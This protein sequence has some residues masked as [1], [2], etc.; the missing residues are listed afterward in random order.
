MP[1]EPDKTLKVQASRLRSIL[2]PLGLAIITEYGQGYRLVGRTQSVTVN[3]S[4]TNS[5]LTAGKVA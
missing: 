1:A 4:A 5:A 2:W 3:T